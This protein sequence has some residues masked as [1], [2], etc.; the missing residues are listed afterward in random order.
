MSLFS[1]NLDI[2]TNTLKVF[3]GEEANL[4]FLSLEWFIEYLF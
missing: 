4:I 1:P 2:I 3:K